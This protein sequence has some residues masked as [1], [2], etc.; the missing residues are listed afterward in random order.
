MKRSILVL[1]VCLLALTATAQ[2]QRAGVP[3]EGVPIDS[4]EMSDPFVLADPATRTYYM[5]GTG[6]MLWKSKDLATWSGPYRVAEMDTASWMGANPMI[7]AAEIHRWKGRYY[8]FA[9]FTNKNVQIDTVANNVIDRRACHILV[10]DKAEGPY[11]SFGAAE[12]LPADKPTLDATL[13]VDKDG[14]PWMVYCHE[15]LQNRNGTVERIRLTDDLRATV[16]ESEVLFR[17][18]DSPWSRENSDDGAIRPN[19]VTDGPF[20]FRTT[21][22]RLGMLWTSWIRDI[23]TQ[24]VAYSQSDELQGPWIQEPEPITP[25]NYGHGMI[26]KTFDGRTLMAVHSHQ[27]LAQDR[28]LRRPHFFTISLK[29][30][31]LVLG[32]EWHP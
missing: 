6:G 16:G 25:P 21:N 30:E 4:I 10:S 24:G 23:Y 2:Q 18:S 28:V 14:T 22:G 3:A 20:V 29:G 8:Y 12:Y 15:W 9:T 13:W 11:R 7:W 27:H 17:A 1:C 26:F 5:T 19:M 32:Q 31:R